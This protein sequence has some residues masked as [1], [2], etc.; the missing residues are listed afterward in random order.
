MFWATFP[1]VFLESHP[2]RFSGRIRADGVRTDTSMHNV[3]NM[4]IR[5]LPRGQNSLERH[6]AP[7][8]L[9]TCV[10]SRPTMCA[11]LVVPGGFARSFSGMP[12]LFT[13]AA[14]SLDSTTIRHH[15][16]HIMQQPCVSCC[17]TFR[18]AGGRHVIICL[19]NI[20]PLLLLCAAHWALPKGQSTPWS[21][22]T[23]L[24]T[25]VPGRCQA[26]NR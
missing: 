21:S 22:P 18:A 14:D 7:Q 1:A 20:R 6:K 9:T 23:V 2:K 26:C 11:Q 12:D 3:R 17:G 5:I 15:D 19:H 13:E 25:S 10:L 24:R 8:M 4:E 16:S